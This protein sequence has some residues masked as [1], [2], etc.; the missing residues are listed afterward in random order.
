MLHRWS[1]EKSGAEQNDYTADTDE[2]IDYLAENG[3][4]NPLENPSTHRCSDC[5]SAYAVDIGKPDG[6]SH[7]TIEIGR[8]H[9]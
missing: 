2:T 1:Q 3:T 6:R 9:V 8:A 4:G 7:E 5:N